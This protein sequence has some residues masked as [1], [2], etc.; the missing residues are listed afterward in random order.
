MQQLRKPSAV[1]K[2]SWENDYGHM[3]IPAVNHPFKSESSSGQIKVW[4]QSKDGED[5]IKQ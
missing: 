1:W 3:G 2:V 4:K 5:V